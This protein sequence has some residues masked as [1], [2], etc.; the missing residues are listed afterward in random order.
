[1]VYS[2]PGDQC[3]RWCFAISDTG[4]LEKKYPN[5]RNSRLYKI[6][7]DVGIWNRDFKM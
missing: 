3:E 6:V 1:M 4:I 2:K 7:N 5:A